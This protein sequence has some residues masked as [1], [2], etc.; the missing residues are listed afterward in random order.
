M[1]RNSL[2]RA[3]CIF[4]CS[5]MIVI[6]AGTGCSIQNTSPPVAKIKPHLQHIHGYTLTDNY[7]WL[8]DKNNSEVIDYLNKENQYTQS[9]TKHTKR[10]QDKLYR[11]MKGRIKETDLQ[12]PTRVD[13]YFY[14]TRTVKGN[15]YPI[16]A[17]KQGSLEAKEEILLDPNKLAEGKKYFRIARY[18]I[19]PNHKLLAYSVD[20]AGSET[21]TV[22][23]KNLE[24][25]KLLKDQIPNTYYSL[26]WGND[27][28]TL[29]YTTLDQ[30][31]R[32]YKAF[33][34]ILGNDASDD[35]L[36]YHEKD[37][38]F[39]VRIS[40]SRSQG[41][42]FLNLA[43]ETTSEV[44]Y[45]YADR[46]LSEF[47]VI[48]PREHKIEYDV[49]HQGR[50]FYIVTNEHAINFKLM[51]SPIKNPG[52]INW[53]T[54]IEHRPEVKLDGV[55]AFE[56]HLAIYERSNALRQLR[57]RN[58]GDNKDHVVSFPEPVYSF[59]TTG[60]EEY[61]TSTIRFSYTSLVTPRSIYD[62]DMNTRKRE[63]KKQTVVLGGYDPSK[64]KS[65][66]IM[67]TASDG[68]KVPITLVYKKGLQKNGHHP[69]LLYGYGSYGSSRDVRFSANRL[70]LLDRGFVYAIAHIR[71]GGDMGRPWYEDGKML[72]KRNTFTD[73]IA[74]AEHLIKEGYTSSD[75]LAIRGGS[76]GGLLMGAVTNMRPDLFKTV[77]AHVPFVDVMNTMLDPSIPLTVIE[78][79]EWGNPNDKTYFDYMMT[80]SPYDNVVAKDYPNM[81]ITA[82]LN[83]PRVQYWEPAKWTAKLRALK[84]ND[85]VLVLKTNMGAGH[86]GSSGRY[87]RIKEKAFE[88]AFLFDTLGIKK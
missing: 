64:Y 25:G 62:Y 52:K 24:T 67:A 58:L 75:L 63:L 14:Y 60:N 68:T 28:L 59:F 45:L 70:T 37:E 50:Y 2:N 6:L 61:K 57:I 19:S 18:R 15:Q 48:R 36:I 33:R 22:N 74:C 4:S 76:A 84:T 29:F 1:M 35:H 88:Y 83:D 23:I 9:M 17:R 43:S 39:F 7:Y 41:F 13:D 30:A 51:R 26:E 69:T 5:L 54:V 82:G 32:P 44:H 11:E 65:E 71:G 12:V 78:Y 55:D 31:K 47:Q 73:F 81:L 79:E 85:N 87:D 10:F 42:L 8:R 3:K 77:L 86:G 66:R 27:N 49:E 21:Y 34:H 80:Y 56:M 20:T 40:K 46:P 72:N 53:E 38:A 16:Y